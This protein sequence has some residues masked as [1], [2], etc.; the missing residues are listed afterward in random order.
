MLNRGFF[1]K[2]ANENLARSAPLEK[3]STCFTS[4]NFG[5]NKDN[6]S[7]RIALYFYGQ[8]IV[9]FHRGL[10]P[11]DPFENHAWLETQ[12]PE[13]KNTSKEINK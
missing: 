7:L 12:Y 3:W 1:K 5:L 4:I 9:Y 11:P 8:I 10:V 13:R 2:K 6:I